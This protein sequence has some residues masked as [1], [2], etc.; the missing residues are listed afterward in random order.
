[1]IDEMSQGKTEQMRQ[2]AF[3]ND[4]PTI[5]IRKRTYAEVSDCTYRFELTFRNGD[6]V[7]G[8]RVV[9]D[10]LPTDAKRKVYDMVREMYPDWHTMRVLHRSEIKP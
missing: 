9:F 8:H 4:V 2:F 3:D 5:E 7:T 10:L 1:M 6:S